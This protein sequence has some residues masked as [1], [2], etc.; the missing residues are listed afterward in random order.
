MLAG[1]LDWRTIVEVPTRAGVRQVLT[2]WRQQLRYWLCGM[3]GHERHIHG[4]DGYLSLRCVF[5]GYTERGWEMGPPRLARRLEGVPG[6]HRLPVSPPSA[7][8]PSVTPPRTEV[9]AETPLL[10]CA[11]SPAP[12]PARSPARHSTGRPTV[13]AV[14]PAR[15]THVPMPSGAPTGALLAVAVV[16]TA[17]ACVLVGR[18]SVA[19]S[20]AGSGPASAPHA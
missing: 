7:A 3:H 13:T 5:C 14:T 8:A 1:Q 10:R 18:A 6:R 15:S 19:P 4:A 12:T 11:A 16:A 20:R 9:R 17:V 2:G